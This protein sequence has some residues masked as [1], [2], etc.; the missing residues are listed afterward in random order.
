MSTHLEI[1]AILMLFHP[2]KLYPLVHCHS[3]NP[4]IFQKPS[5]SDD[6]EGSCV[7]TLLG[8]ICREQPAHIDLDDFPKAGWWNLTMP[9]LQ[10]ISYREWSPP[11]PTLTVKGWKGSWKCLFLL[12]WAHPERKYPYVSLWE[13]LLCIHLSPGPGDISWRS[14]SLVWTEFWQ[15]AWWMPPVRPSS[16]TGRENSH[17][18]LHSSRPLYPTPAGW[19]ERTSRAQDGQSH[20]VEGAWDSEQPW[21]PMPIW[22]SDLIESVSC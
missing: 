11:F 17:M 15:G 22:G 21:K 14:F 1:W 16:D 8:S 6:A 3:Y 13:K 18:A 4:I 2:N 19:M 5:T 10:T 20:N 7:H 12:A 9:G